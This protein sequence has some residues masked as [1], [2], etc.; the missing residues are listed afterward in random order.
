[1]GM[2]GYIPKLSLDAYL[3]DMATL[4]KWFKGEVNKSKQQR[5]D[6]IAYELNNHEAFYTGDIE[7]TLNTLGSDY[8]AKEVTKVFYKMRE[9]QSAI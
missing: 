1:M 6:Y 2:G 5:I 4:R 9:T 8:T 7:D 3:D